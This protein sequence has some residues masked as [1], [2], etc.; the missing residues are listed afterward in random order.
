M[1]T[2]Q[3]SIDLRLTGSAYKKISNGFCVGNLQ[4]R[5]LIVVGPGA[6]A[7]FRNGRVVE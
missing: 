3:T 4:Q 5:R 2:W 6:L 1:G 7:I